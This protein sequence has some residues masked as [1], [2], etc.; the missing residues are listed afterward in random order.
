MTREEAIAR[1]LQAQGLDHAPNKHWG[2]SFV[3]TLVALGMLKL[4]EPK[5]LI[6]R[7]AYEALVSF[8]RNASEVRDIIDDL[9]RAGLK[10]VEK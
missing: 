9:S 8:D 7:T 6:D 4:D 3:D 1:V 2:A 5:S 10:I